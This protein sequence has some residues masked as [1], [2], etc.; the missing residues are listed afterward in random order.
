M[1]EWIIKSVIS[2]E[3]DII[4]R[5]FKLCGLGTLLDKD[6]I[7]ELNGRIKELGDTLREML[8]TSQVDFEGLAYNPYMDPF[9][10]AMRDLL[11]NDIVIERISTFN[12]KKHLD[13]TK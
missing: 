11:L 5:S 13:S 8:T 4:C 9:E 1:I 3:E 7:C 2:V 10:I 12:L 6:N